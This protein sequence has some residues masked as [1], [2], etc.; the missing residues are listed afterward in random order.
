MVILL[1]MPSKDLPPQCD[2]ELTMIFIDARSGVTSAA[3]TRRGSGRSR[4]SARSPL[5]NRGKLFKQTEP[6]LT[7]SVDVLTGERSIRY[8][9]LKPINKA[10]QKALTER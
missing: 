8:Y 6:R 3:E 7:T 2:S 10:S 1:C 9:L 5:I 4:A